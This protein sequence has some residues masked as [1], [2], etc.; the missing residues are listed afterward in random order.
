MKKKLMIMVM[1]GL[2]AA[3]SGEAAFAAEKQTDDRILQLIESIRD[4]ITG[5]FNDDEA[6]P[7]LAPEAAS[8]AVQQVISLT[9]AARRSAGLP[10]L[11]AGSRLSRL[12]QQKAED[13]AENG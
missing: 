1:A 9:N 5:N 11:K 4:Y 3:G 7:E 12:A 10:E 2:I 8:S 13:M 6:E